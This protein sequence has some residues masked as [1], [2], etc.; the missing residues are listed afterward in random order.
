MAK[1]TSPK[2]RSRKKRSG[3][4]AVPGL[5]VV[6]AGSAH[7]RPG[8]H[9]VGRPY[10]NYHLLPPG[11]AAV[12]AIVDRLAGPTA[13]EKRQWRE[14]LRNAVLSAQTAGARKIME[15]NNRDRASRAAA[16]FRAL[17][18]LSSYVIDPTFIPAIQVA[19]SI[20]EAENPA[21]R[22]RALDLARGLEHVML[23]ESIVADEQR[24]AK[25]VKRKNPGKPYMAGLAE[26]LVASWHEWTGEFP[27]KTRVL[28]K[29]TTSRRTLF[30]DFA[31]AALADL[32]M[33]NQP[34]DYLVRSAIAH[35]QK[36][37]KHPP[38]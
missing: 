12:D 14:T 29:R 13:L 21:F 17:H 26:S 25:L 24:R 2:R 30:W 34:I 5:S 32:C 4:F 7:K 6:L 1:K 33:P 27:S 15:F 10:T 18:I 11:I 36:A 22:D 16:A 37:E 3:R 19:A 9:V 28:A 35:L 31:D 8:D 20:V 38:K 23:L